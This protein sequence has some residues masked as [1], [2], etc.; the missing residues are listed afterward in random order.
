MEETQ[1]P[2]KNIYKKSLAMALIRKGH[3]I[4]HTMRNREN[5][6]YQI[7]VFLDSPK[8]IE[9]LLE[10]TAGESQDHTHI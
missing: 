9:D 5:P 3:D 2:K 7:F 10:L 1:E 6:S 8:L 4:C